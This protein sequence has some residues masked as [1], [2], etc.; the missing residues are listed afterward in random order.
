M[1]LL[2]VSILDNKLDIGYS[3]DLAVANS[4]AKRPLSHEIAIRYQIPERMKKSKVV[5]I[6]TPR[7][8]IL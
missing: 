3:L 6:R 7:F 5:P 1:G 4:L 8:R 2:G